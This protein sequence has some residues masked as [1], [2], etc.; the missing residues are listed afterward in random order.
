MSFDMTDEP[1]TTHAAAQE[2]SKR[3]KGFSISLETLAN[4]LV[5]SRL[6]RAGLG[7]KESSE[8]ELGR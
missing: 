8:A 2:E 7:G 5:R 1:Y 4:K 6:T 3:G